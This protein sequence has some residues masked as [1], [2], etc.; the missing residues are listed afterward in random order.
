MLV[1]REAV[2]ADAADL[3]AVVVTG[4][5]VLLD[6]GEL[7]VGVDVARQRRAAA[8]ERDAAAAVNDA[9]QRRDQRPRRQQ[10]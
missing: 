1:R 10:R 5:A 8:A 4:G 3:R 7:R 9:R 6:R 2:E